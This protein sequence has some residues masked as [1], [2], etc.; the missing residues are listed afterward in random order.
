MTISEKVA[1]IAGLAEGM[2]IDE[3]TDQ[4]KLN[5]AIIDVLKDIADELD[6][7]DETLDDMAEIVGELEEQVE[8]LEDDVF[9]CDCHDFDFEGDDL[10]EIT[11]RSCENSVAIDMSMLDDGAINCPNCGEKIEFDID[12]IG[13]D[14]DD[15]E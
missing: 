6:E 9:G 11:C 2:K 4:G 15:E 10:Y 1:F 12:F 3:E 7:I 8:E 13:N 14:N 5:L